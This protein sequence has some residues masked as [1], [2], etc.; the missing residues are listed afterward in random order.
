MVDWQP[1]LGIIPPF[2]EPAWFKAFEAYKQYPE[3]KLINQGMSL[4]EFKFIFYMEYFHRLLGRLIGLVYFIPFIVFLY[5]GGLPVGLK[6]R[7]WILL[8]LGACQ[9]LMGWFM[10]KS[11]LV[12]DPHVSQYRL[13]AHLLLA[14][15]IFI[16]M[17]RI[18]FGLIFDN[19]KSS[20]PR[21]SET[22]FSARISA[23]WVFFLTLLMITTGGFMAGTRAGFIYNSWPKMGQEWIPEMV[24]ALIPWWKNLFEN[25][26][27]IQF[28]H[29]WLAI[30]VVLAVVF[31]GLKVLR[32]ARRP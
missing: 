26:M 2:S 15:I 19:L 27:A 11:G 5:V 7:L 31:L 4:S 17:V 20:D 3:Y 32:L 10:V 24:W 1:L 6:R 21:T 25:P 30:A 13:T 16:L 29:R 14:V 28:I 8:A 12:S 18:I 9:G 22:G 23:M